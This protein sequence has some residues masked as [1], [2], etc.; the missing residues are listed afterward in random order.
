MGEGLR[1]WASV[2]NRQSEGVNCGH[3]LAKVVCPV[4]VATG[5]VR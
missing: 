5:A 3:H 4:T 2:R 1:H